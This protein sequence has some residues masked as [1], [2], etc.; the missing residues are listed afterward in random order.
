MVAVR[1]WVEGAVVGTGLVA[2]AA[3]GRVVLAAATLAYQVTA[4]GWESEAAGATTARSWGVW[5][6]RSWHMAQQSVGRA[7]GHLQQLGRIRRLSCCC[8]AIAVA[9]VQLRTGVAHRKRLML[10]H[11][12]TWLVTG[13]QHDCV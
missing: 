4:G 1:G 12:A 3:T 8:P 10:Y 13:G 9:Q 11:A 7:R 2:E 5:K 6:R